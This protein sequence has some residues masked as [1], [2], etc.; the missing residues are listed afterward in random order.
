MEKLNANITKL[1]GIVKNKSLNPLSYWCCKIQRHLELSPFSCI[2]QSLFY[3][4]LPLVDHLT[5]K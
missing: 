4:A 5:F 2:L 1:Q 3:D